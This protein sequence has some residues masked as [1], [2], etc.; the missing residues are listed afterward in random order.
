MDAFDLLV[1]RGFVQQCSHPDEVRQALASGPVTFYIGFDP[2]ADSLHVGHLVQIMAMS[3]LQ[4]AGH[5][6]IALVGGGTSRVGDPSGRTDMRQMLSDEQ[7]AANSA[8]FRDQLGHFLVMDGERGRMV[9]NA[10]WLMGLK[11]IPFLREIG[12]QFSVNRMLA[13]E[14]YKQRLERGLS[15]IEFNYQI[16]QSYDFLVLHDRHECRLQIGGDDQWGNILPGVDLVR[17]IRQTTVWGLTTPLLTTASGTKMGKTAA[18]ALWLSAERTKPF[19][20]WQYW[21]NTDDRD[22]GRFLRLFTF[23]PEEECARLEALTGA[24]LREAKR[25]LANEATT[26]AHGEE[27]ARAAEA[28][29]KAMAASSASDDLPTASIAAGTRLCVALTEAGLT[30]S[31]GEAR[32]LVSQGGITWDG[33]KAEDADRAFTGEE[34]AAGVVVRLG[35]KRAVRFVTVQ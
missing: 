32:R 16:L 2:T 8:V 11:Y 26:L 5:R 22:V 23:L 13:A 10:D 4:R 35:R 14:A 17:R 24:D 21:Y 28:G 7:I 6:A 20:Y 34:L 3:W 31:N 25:V 19:D 15:F 12:S 33:E 9:D 30:K 27:A 18:G 1:A 29:A